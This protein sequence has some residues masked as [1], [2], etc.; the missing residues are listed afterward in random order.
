MRYVCSL[1]FGALE[2]EGI[3][4]NNEAEATQIALKTFRPAILSID[5]R[6]I[7]AT[8][9]DKKTRPLIVT[10]LTISNAPKRRHSRRVLFK[11]QEEKCKRVVRNAEREFGER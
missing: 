8:V 11:E 1:D 2:I 6:S 10:K 9:T 5:E 3:E 4:A 7:K